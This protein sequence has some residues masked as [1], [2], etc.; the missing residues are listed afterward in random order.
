MPTLNCLLDSSLPLMHLRISEC[1]F[2]RKPSLV[3]TVLGSCISATFFH[4]PSGMAA[5]CHAMLP[6]AAAGPKGGHGACRFVD[7]A[8]TSIL[9]R[10]RRCNIKPG[11][12]DAKLFGGACSMVQPKHLRPEQLDTGAYW[13]L[14]V[15]AR[16]VEVAR[17]LLKQA[18][19]SL[20]G[21][22]VGG[23]SG[24]KLFFHTATGDVWVKTLR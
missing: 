13:N 23:A 6:Q 8:I 15:G 22:H 4:A 20:K 16:N 1:I 7:V 12:L 11:D 9:E 21:E 3:T 18:G 14:N 24:R 10:F 19:I 5:I 2:T 17:A